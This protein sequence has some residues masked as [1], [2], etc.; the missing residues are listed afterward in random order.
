MGLVDHSIIAEDG[1]CFTQQQCAILCSLDSSIVYNVL[2]PC[3][4]GYRLPAVPW[5]WL[6]GTGTPLTTP[7]TS[8]AAPLVLTPRTARRRYYSTELQCAGPCVVT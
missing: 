7:S 4:S 5:S 3:G 1:E 2:L 6:G 8:T